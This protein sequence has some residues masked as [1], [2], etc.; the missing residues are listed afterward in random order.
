MMNDY[1]NQSMY[2]LFRRLAAHISKKRHYQLSLLFVL[3]L[4]SS[5]T[6]IVSIGAV[7]PF[8]AILSSP[9][10]VYSNES[11]QPIIMFFEFK[12]A[13]ELALPITFSFIAATLIAG[14]MRLLLVFVNTRLSFATGHD[15]SIDIYNKT[16]RQ[17][18]YVHIDRNSS[19]IVNG[20]ATKTDLVIFQ[21]ILPLLNFFGAIVMIVLI[22]LALIIIDP[23]LAISMMGGIGL[24]YYSLVR[25]TSSMLAENSKK[26]ADKSTVRV[27]SLQEGLGGIRDILLSGTQNTYC[28]IYEDADLPLRRAQAV[29]AFISLS[30]RY[31]MEALGMVLI[32]TL[33]ISF[34]TTNDGIASYIPLL[35]GLAFGAQKLLPMVQL[36]YQGW[37]SILG[38]RASLVDT[39]EFLDQK[40]PNTNSAKSLTFTKNI[41][42]DNVSFSYQSNNKIV[43]DGI[44]LDIPKGACIGFVGSTGSGKSTLLD[45]IMGL[46]NPTDG[47]ISVDGSIL[48]SD[49]LTAWQKY[50]CHVPQDIF[51]ADTSIKENIAFGVPLHEIDMQ[52]VV[53]A[54]LKAQLT[55]VID[56]LPLKYQ[57]LVGERGVRL[58]GGQKQRIGIARA[59]YAESKVLIFD[60]ATSALDGDTEKDVMREIARLDDEVT[61]LMIAHRITTLEN[62]D[63][64]VELKE[65]K[66]AQVGDYDSVLLN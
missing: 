23:L 2:L 38:A 8:I 35:G 39:L 56:E 3:I 15:L 36:A 26:I 4:C 52:R 21:V 58:S 28:K 34:T 31:A 17:P 66:I 57:T 24:I 5:L 65:G 41:F 19:E 18:F 37:S 10:Q 14:A 40:I 43:L 42:L 50:I 64:I 16:L 6:E 47:K 11:L 33:A 25:L 51:L 20:V 1:E 12:S 22:T 55:A 7:I 44:S 49:C 62:C 48:T 59:L 30:P 32:A 9:E 61:I 54:A 45:I 29:N 13:Q 53:E 63:Q 46:L 27:K 60:E